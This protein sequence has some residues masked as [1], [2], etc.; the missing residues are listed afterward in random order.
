MN[1]KIEKLKEEF[2]N[3]D[4]IK[5]FEIEAI[6]KKTGEAEHI[7]FWIEAKK[8]SLIAI[9]PSLTEKEQRSKKI[10]F[11]SIVLDASF[12]LDENLQEL[13]EECTTAILDSDFF[14]LT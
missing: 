11:K 7:C 4:L 2:R 6:H 14:T 9:H 13:H 5:V 12:S 3:L 8:H 1:K 10:A